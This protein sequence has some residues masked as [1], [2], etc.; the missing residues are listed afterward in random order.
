LK[1][2]SACAG[3]E[4]GLEESGRL[5]F[6]D[7][8]EPVRPDVRTLEQARGVLWNMTAVEPAELYYMYRGVS[9]RADRQLFERERIR[10]DITVL[11]PGAVSGEFVKT[12]GHYHPA[13]DGTGIQYPEV[14]EVISGKAH[15]LLQKPRGEPLALSDVVIV[16]ALPGDKVLIPPGY[17]H[18]TINTGGEPLVMANLIEREFTSL[19]EHFAAAHGAAYYEVLEEDTPVFVEN[20]HYKEIPEPRLVEPKDIPELGL[21]K[22][23]PLY[24]AFVSQPAAFEYLVKPHLFMGALEAVLA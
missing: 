2:L 9:R 17:G 12:V 22:A 24:V 10:Y 14:Y 4:L 6:G 8:L 11:V 21:V 7:D 15:Y 3:I 1:D 20:E 19:Y 13:A 5:A 16:E 18:V 23:T